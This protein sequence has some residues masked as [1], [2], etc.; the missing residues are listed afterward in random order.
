MPGYLVA[1]IVSRVS[2]TGFT[3]MVGERG[4][5]AIAHRQEYGE[6]RTPPRPFIQVGPRIEKILTDTLLAD[7]RAAL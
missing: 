1:H 3:L 5:G 6:G 4:V 2:A 7:L